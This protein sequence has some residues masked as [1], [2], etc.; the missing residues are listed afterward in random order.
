MITNLLGRKVALMPAYTGHEVF[1][2]GERIPV[3]KVVMGEIVAVSNKRVMVVH[4]DGRLQSWR[5]HQ[6]KLLPEVARNG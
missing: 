1:M 6:L 2:D 3:E 5:P 4:S